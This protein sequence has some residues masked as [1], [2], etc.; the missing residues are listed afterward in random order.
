MRVP[1]GSILTEIRTAIN[2]GVSA[3]IKK[4]LTCREDIKRAYYRVRVIADVYPSQLLGF[5]YRDAFP[6]SN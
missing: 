4:P 1:I 5:L 3:Y 6:I 2:I